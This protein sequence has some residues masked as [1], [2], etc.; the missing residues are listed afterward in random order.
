LPYSGP[1]AF[2]REPAKDVMA[3]LVPAIHA[4]F[5]AKDVEAR[6]KRGHDAFIAVCD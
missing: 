1:R 5:A 6:D 3:R 2:A 4:L